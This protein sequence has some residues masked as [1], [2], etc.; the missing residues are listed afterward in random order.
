[1]NILYDLPF[2]FKVFV[3]TVFIISGFAKITTHRQFKQ[4]L[5]TFFGQRFILPLSYAVPIVEI[6]SA[7]LVLFQA[8]VMY[9]LILI[10]IL[11]LSFIVLTWKALRTGEEIKCH[12]FGNLNDEKFGKTTY[13]KNGLLIT[14]SLAVLIMTD[15]GIQTNDY[16]TSDWVSMVLSSAGILIMHALWSSYLS[17]MKGVTRNE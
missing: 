15:Q 14:L 12:C 6:L 16:T 17:F 9:G 7:S 10:I 1:M 13:L 8:T 5:G 2:I 11:C 3:A 4:T